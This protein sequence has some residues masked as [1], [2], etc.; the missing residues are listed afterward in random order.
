MKNKKK[1]LTS[2]FHIGDDQDYHKK[3][4][5]NDKDYDKKDW[6]K[7]D[8]PN[9]NL[10]VDHMYSNI[11]H[12]NDNGNIRNLDKVHS[13]KKKEKEL[14]SNIQKFSVN[15]HDTL[16]LKQK[17][18]MTHDEIEKLSENCLEHNTCVS[19]GWKEVNDKNY[20][21][22]KNLNKNILLSNDMNDSKV[23]KL[24]NLRSH[25]DNSESM[26]NNYRDIKDKREVVE[27]N[28]S[29]DNNTDFDDV[30]RKFKG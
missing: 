10:K 28:I 3:C 13:E 16:S 17:C 23:E 29:L 9:E 14:L 26:N 8:N 7:Q 27:Y 1:E 6:I 5:N 22:D 19:K 15:D 4:D 18:L 20:Q 12:N 30:M 24:N 11:F 25:M 2:H 21:K